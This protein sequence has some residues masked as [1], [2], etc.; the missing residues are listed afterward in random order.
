MRVELDSRLLLAYLSASPPR[1]T[2]TFRFFLL[3]PSIPTPSFLHFCIST[4]D[5]RTPI[6][7]FSFPF[8][9][10]SPFPSSTSSI[11]STDRIGE[12]RRGD[13]GGKG[14]ARNKTRAEGKKEEEE[15]RERRM[16]GGLKVNVE[17]GSTAITDCYTYR[18]LVRQL[19]PI[20]FFFSSS[21]K[22]TR[23][24]EPI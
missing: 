24:T 1:S 12:E 4:D 8:R 23:T 5:R 11:C 9:L 16:Y 14:S 21:S 10:P 17:P 13:E 7:T 22:P 15:D 20:L 6:Q 18:C 2:G 19:L 3:A